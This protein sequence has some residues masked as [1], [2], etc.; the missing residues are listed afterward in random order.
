MKEF[1]VFIS[2]SVQYG[3]IEANTKEEAIAAAL[4]WWMERQ[5]NIIVEEREVIEND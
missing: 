1:N 2:D 5:P 3:K 4:D